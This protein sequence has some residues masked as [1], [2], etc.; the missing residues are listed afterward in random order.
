MGVLIVMGS[1]LGA[2]GASFFPFDKNLGVS[3]IVAGVAFGAGIVI[4]AFNPEANVSWVRA[5]ILY[6]IIE[7]V[8]EIVDQIAIS[9]FD[10]PAFLIAIIVGAV[11]MFIYPNKN[12]LWMR[13]SNTVVHKA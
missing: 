9:R 7:V 13:G 10:L 12:E 6:C 8:Y 1:A 4:A 2:Y 5:V 11:L 3:G